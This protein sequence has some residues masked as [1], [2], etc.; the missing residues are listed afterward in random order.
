MKKLISCSLVLT[1]LMYTTIGRAVNPEKPC[2][3]E[4]G[5]T[6]RNALIITTRTL[7]SIIDDLYTAMN[8]A[9]ELQEDTTQIEEHT[10]KYNDAVKFFR[11][12]INSSLKLTGGAE[13]TPEQKSLVLG[14]CGI[15]KD[16]TTNTYDWSRRTGGMDTLTAKESE[17]CAL[18]SDDNASKLSFG[19]L[20]LYN[21]VLKPKGYTSAELNMAYGA[22]SSTS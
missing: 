20:K 18:A 2:G 8:D 21:D 7:A 1:S 14:L 11:V 3:S 16:E 5:F 9:V 22:L 19:I 10:K 17:A 13:A 6:G 4:A 12:K 15:S